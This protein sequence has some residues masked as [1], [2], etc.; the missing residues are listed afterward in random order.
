MKTGPSTRLS[1]INAAAVMTKRH[2][3]RLKSGRTESKP[4]DYAEHTI[5][6]DQRRRKEARNILE[7]RRMRRD[8]GLDEGTAASLDGATATR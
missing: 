8:L 6:E 1:Q 7:D 2:A 3:A 4:S 5:T